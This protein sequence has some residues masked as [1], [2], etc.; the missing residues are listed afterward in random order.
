MSWLKK[1]WFVVLVILIV[2]SSFLYYRKREL[3][4]VEKLKS[5]FEKLKAHILQ[6]AKKYETDL[7][8]PGVEQKKLLDNKWGA[9]VYNQA[10]EKGKTLEQMAHNSARWM[11]I[12]GSDYK[13]DKEFVDKH[14]ESY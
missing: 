3:D 1:N 9:N 7:Y 11:M 10:K 14:I 13:Y 12:Y 5:D 2:L 4:K 8:T 6:L